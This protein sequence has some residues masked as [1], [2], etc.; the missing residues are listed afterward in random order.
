M[1]AD[2]SPFIEQLNRTPLELRTLIEGRSDAWL[3]RKHAAEVVSPRQAV[4][5]LVLCEGYESWIVR[6]R[7]I[8]DPEKPMVVEEMSSRQLLEMYSLTELLDKFQ[9]LR[10]WS[11]H[12]LEAMQLSEEDLEVRRS[13]SEDWSESV[14]ELLATW[15]AHDLYHLGQ[16]L[17]SFAAPF[18]TQIGPYQHF[19]NLPNFN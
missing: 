14:G 5:H 2:L 6:I 13:D 1:L 8:L 18:Q 16:I 4:A 3:D 15:P 17:K 12:E 10:E 11:I 19:L 9:S 7:A